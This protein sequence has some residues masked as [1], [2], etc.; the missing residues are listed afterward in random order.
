MQNRS[1]CC[2][3]DNY[4]N[5]EYCKKEGVKTHLLRYNKSVLNTKINTKI[6]QCKAQRNTPKQYSLI[7]LYIIVMDG[8]L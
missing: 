5:M 4:M 7:L 1:G 2:F 3:V 6:I 8:E